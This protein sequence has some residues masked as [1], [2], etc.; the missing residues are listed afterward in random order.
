M[1]Q[2]WQWG[3]DCI[4]VI[5]KIRTPFFDAMFVF[6]SSLGTQMF[7]MLLIPVLYWCFDRKTAARI[8]ILFFISSWLNSVM[9]DF[10][11]HPRPYNLDESVQIGHTGGPGI[12]SGHAQQSLVLWSYLAVWVKKPL[13]TSFAVFIILAIALSRLYLGVHFPTDI[14]GGW[15]LGALL[16]LAAWPA[17]DK[18]EIFA[19]KL[20]PAL[21][22]SVVLI[23]PV[24]LSFILP[25]RWSVSP[26]GAASGF[27]IGLIIEQHS[28]GFAPAD[29]V[30][31][32]FFRYISGIIVLFIIFFTGKH[33]FG[34]TTPGYLVYLFIHSWIMGLWVSAG[35]PRMFAKLKLS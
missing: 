6:I 27:C 14:L 22:G 12:P 20:N 7:Y 24:L 3:I 30:K 18:I 29:S 2:V 26:I 32:G 23:V 25:S 10:I 28:T 35:A 34:I 33:I 16:L 13:F 8:F 4:I 21:L 11:S 19:Q 9:K 1:E 15:F 5:Q 17:F 31:K